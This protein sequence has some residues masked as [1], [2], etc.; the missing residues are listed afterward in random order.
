MVVGCVGLRERNHKKKKERKKGR[1]GGMVV[2][3]H[4]TPIVGHGE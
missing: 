4:D 2:M 3:G 1:D